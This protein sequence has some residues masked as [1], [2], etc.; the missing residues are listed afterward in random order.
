MGT[1]SAEAPAAQAA[2]AAARRRRWSRRQ[3]RQAGYFYLFVS[4]WLLGFVCLS[5]IPIGLGLT[6]S[7]SNYDGFNLDTARW[8]GFD[9]YVR[10]WHDPDV[11]FALGRTFALMAVVVPGSVLLQ[12]TL[13]SLLNEAIRARGL[14]RTL[15]YLPSVVPLVAA[16]WIWKSVGAPD[17]LLN[18]VLQTLGAGPVG[19]L[20]DHSTDL[21]RMWLLWAWSGAGMLIFLAALQGV[22]RELRE[23]AAI[24]GAKPLQIMRKIVLPIISPAIFFQLVSTMFVAFQV[25][26]EPILLSPGLTL[27]SNA[28][29]PENNV[30]VTNA[31]QQVFVNQRFGY[32][33]ALLWILFAI[34]V[35]VT[36]LLFATARFWVFYERPGRGRK[37]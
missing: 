1:A 17:G 4:P 10:A 11:R 36:L 30:F 19:W 21:L 2:G 12:L 15:F 31:F 25:F 3:A 23:A 7:F 9:N 8:V 14:F 37:A 20:V 27:L 35:L 5:L 33:A 24:D 6:I 16:A 18:T 34:A 22:P 28:P 29:P 13:A 26:A 32:G